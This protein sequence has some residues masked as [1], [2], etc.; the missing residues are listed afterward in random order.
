MFD[1][2]SAVEKAFVL[3]KILRKV[4]QEML[5]FGNDSV[6]NDYITKNLTQI[7]KEHVA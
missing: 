6:Q 1:L 5:F 3:W 7:E 4:V 2:W